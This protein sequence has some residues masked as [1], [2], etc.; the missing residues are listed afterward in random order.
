MDTLCCLCHTINEQCTLLLTDFLC[1]VIYFFVLYI[2]SFNFIDT[3]E[4]LIKTTADGR[5]LTQK[6][7]VY[8]TMPAQK[9][10]VYPTT[11]G[12]LI[13]SIL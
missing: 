3:I 11:P 6:V 10:K 4:Q 1:Q 7:K 8:P 9:V 2:F 12:T 13:L 5:P